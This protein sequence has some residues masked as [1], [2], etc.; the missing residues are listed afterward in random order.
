MEQEKQNQ[1]PVDLSDA[2]KGSDIKNE[3]KWQ[4]PVQ[5]FDP[6]APR[7]IRWVITGSGGLIKNEKQA[8][9]A[10]VVLFVIALFIS[11]L[12]FMRSG[13]YVKRGGPGPSEE[14]LEKYRTIQPF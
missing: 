3:D 4:E 1:G 7:V 2:L 14:E 5:S 10:L 9:I 6:G 13:T 8:T 12:M 11:G